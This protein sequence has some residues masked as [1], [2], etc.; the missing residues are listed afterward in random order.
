MQ[1]SDGSAIS[2]DVKLDI[3]ITY[4]YYKSCHSN[5]LILPE[6][7][8]SKIFLHVIFRSLPTIWF[9]SHKSLQICMHLYVYYQQMLWYNF[10]FCEDG[11]HIYILNLFSVYCDYALASR[12]VFW[13]HLNVNYMKIF[14]VWFDKL[15]L[16]CTWQEDWGK[17]LTVY[18]SA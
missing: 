17:N 5:K 7:I 1:I 4:T 14:P 15:W 16:C 9:M 10:W 2:H 13:I 6:A 3:C 8:N 11:F 18:I 12:V